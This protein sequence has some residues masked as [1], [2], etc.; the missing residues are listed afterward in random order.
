M[1]KTV[2]GIEFP[3]KGI[4]TGGAST[5]DKYIPNPSTYDVQENDLAHDESTL[6]SYDGYL[7]MDLVRQDVYKLVVSWDKLT[8]EQ[9]NLLRFA[10]HTP[11]FK[12]KFLFDTLD[13]ETGE[14]IDP[15]TTCEKTYVQG[16]RSFKMHSVDTGET[17]WTFSLSLISF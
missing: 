14:V 2:V 16:S 5:R 8:R 6:R 11:G 17:Y 12:L 4:F 13:Y 10:S 7:S 3:D 1:N 15:Y 9:K